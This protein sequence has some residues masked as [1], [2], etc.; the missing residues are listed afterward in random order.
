MNRDEQEEKNP[1]MNKDEQEENNPT[2]NKDESTE[3][4][5][6]ISKDIHHMI[7]TV[8]STVYPASKII[9]ITHTV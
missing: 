6:D 4:Y 3:M 9:G 1:T 5:P 2:M 8:K 7:H